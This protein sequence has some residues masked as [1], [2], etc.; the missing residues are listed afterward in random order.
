MTKNNNNNNN[1]YPSV[2]NE[3]VSDAFYQFWAHL[4]RVCERG[5]EGERGQVADVWLSSFI[6]LVCLVFE[7]VINIKLIS[8]VTCSHYYNMTITIVSLHFNKLM[9][10][11]L[12]YDINVNTVEHGLPSTG[13]TQQTPILCDITFIG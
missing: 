2:A 6:L 12:L 1:T 11:S 13:S 9:S 4:D 7:V 10:L 5:R 8:T 3:H